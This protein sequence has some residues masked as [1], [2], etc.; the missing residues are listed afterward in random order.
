[1]FWIAPE[2]MATTLQQNRQGRVLRRIQPQSPI[3]AVN[4][5]VRQVTAYDRFSDC[6]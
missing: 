6:C 5:L 1:V 3:P 4:L 2:G